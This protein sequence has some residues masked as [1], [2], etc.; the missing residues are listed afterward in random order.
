MR[1]ADRP[2]G[3]VAAKY[4]VTIQIPAYH[5]PGGGGGGGGALGYL[6]GCICSLS[7]LKNTPKALIS[8]QK[9]TLTLIKR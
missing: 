1:P 9:S 3:I 7:K 5:A 4:D 2:T 8:G 6:G